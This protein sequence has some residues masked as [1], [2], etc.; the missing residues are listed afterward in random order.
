M[1][2][3]VASLRGR[4]HIRGRE[5]RVSGISARVVTSTPRYVPLTDLASWIAVCHLHTRVDATKRSP[6][7]GRVFEL[8]E[9]VFTAKRRAAAPLTFDSTTARLRSSYPLVRDDEET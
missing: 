1:R 6:V 7:L 5:P 9:S 8:L 3:G 2:A 4:W